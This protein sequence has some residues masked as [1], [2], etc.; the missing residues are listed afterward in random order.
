LLADWERLQYT[1]SA[2]LTATVDCYL[3]TKFY[4]LFVV[5]LF[6]GELYAERYKL[7]D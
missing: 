7:L 2:A 4:L 1:I 5:T 6:A 3:E